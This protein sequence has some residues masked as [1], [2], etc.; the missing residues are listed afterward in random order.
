MT[1]NKNIINFNNFETPDSKFNAVLNSRGGSITFSNSGIRGK[2]FFNLSIDSFLKCLEDIKNNLNSFVPHSNYVE[3]EWRKLG[4][5]FFTD[6]A[7]IAQIG[8]QTKPLFTTLSKLIMWANNLNMNDLD[9]ELTINLDEMMLSKA[10]HELNNLAD[11]YTPEISDHQIITN[12]QID[13][14]SKFIK[15][16]IKREQNGGPSNYFQASFSSD[17]VKFNSALGFYE[18]LYSESFESELFK[19]NKNNITKKIL[20]I[21]ENIFNKSSSFYKYSKK[22]SHHMPRAILGE[23]NYLSFLSEQECRSDNEFNLDMF[24]QNCKSSNLIFSKNLITRYIT[25]LTTKPFVLLTGLSGSGK[26]KLAQSFAQWISEDESQY[27]IVPV[28]ADWTNREPLLG[29]VNALDT[30]EY[31]I[32]E[33]G[34]LELIIR[35]N[36]NQ[37]KPY[38]LILDEMNLSHVERYFADFL[39][40][41]ESNDKFR[42]HNDKVDP[43]SDV[44]HELSWPK[45]LFV[46]GTVNIDETTY[47]FSPKVLD[48]ANVIE[49]KVNTSEIEQFLKSPNV[50]DLSK[51][52]NQGSSMGQSFVDMAKNKDF[53]NTSTIDLNKALVEFFKEL[54]RAGAEFGYRTG[55]EINRLYLQLTEINPDLSEYEKIDIA[56]M[57]KLL[58][59]LHG[60]R[61]K[62]CPILEILA[63]LCVESEVKVKD[64]FLDNQEEAKYDDKSKVKYPLSLEKIAR[65]YKGAID[66]GFTSYAEA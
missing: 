59:K 35:A 11:L 15:W 49:F 31:V 26:T 2:K 65:M 33:N 16:F 23:K 9:P 3:K 27:C 52:V 54:K 18:E 34:A 62:L 64:E 56:V 61:R 14:K 42:L 19:F 38:L 17:P 21:K 6:P 45:N 44:P 24:H 25:S 28:G 30:S 10:I 36:G 13:W 55:M 57:Q 22:T 8:V 51:L 39:S 46:V 50:I 63:G 41:M 53:P 58:P 5:D 12:E 29:Y 48:R 66:N 20:E 4:Q 47:M 32:P 37:E 1:L 40:V 7:S 43:K 60:S